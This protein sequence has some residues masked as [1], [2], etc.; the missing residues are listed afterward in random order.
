[1]RKRRRALNAIIMSI[2]MTVGLF[3][4]M[5]DAL[6]V[7]AEAITVTNDMTIN[8]ETEDDYHLSDDSRLNVGSQGKVKGNIYCSGGVVVNEGY[9]RAVE[10]S[11][12]DFYN[13]SG[14]TVDSIHAGYGKV[15]NKGDITNLGLA[16]NSSTYASVLEMNGGKVGT[17]SSDGSMGLPQIKLSSGTIQ[18]LNVSCDLQALGTANVDNLGGS[19]TLSGSG[20]VH[21]GGT[22]NLS[23]DY[24]GTSA[25]LSVDKNTQITIAAG[26]R[27]K[28]YYN[29]HAYVLGT[30]GTGTLAELAGRTV[31][32]AAELEDTIDW[33]SS[34]SFPTGKFL[35]GDEVTATFTA[36]DGY[37]FPTG[38]AASTSGN[39]SIST[40]RN[41]TTKITVTYI[42]AEEM[43]DTVTVTLPPA[44]EKTQP[45]TETGTGSVTVA[46]LYYGTQP[47]P[48]AESSTN[49]TEGVIYEY[50]IRGAA[51]ST[52]ST[53]VPEQV[54]AYTLRATFPR[55][56]HYT[57][58]T[59]V[60]DFSIYYLPVPENPCTISG[61]IG[62]NNF[63]ISRLEV[64]PPEGYKI[65]DT[66]GGEYKDSILVGDEKA[67]AAI[68]LMRQKD[69][70]KTAAI[71]FGTY[72]IDITPPRIEA[73]NG[74]EYF[75]DY[76]EIS[77]SDLRLD[78]ISINGER[79]DFG[80]TSCTAEL[81]SNDESTEYVIRAVDEAGN[82]STVTVIIS[83]EWLKTGIVPADRVLKLN[84]QREY[85][86][87]DGS[88]KVSGDNNVYNGGQTFYVGSRGSYT[89]TVN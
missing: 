71:P 47:S 9:V 60:C 15:V 85:K 24:S 36:A 28:V 18:N 43:A 14:A 33:S 86:L 8:T 38:Y 75:A 55:K 42:F 77:I 4:G 29:N 2:V 83:A 78:G 32:V 73:E 62:K 46:D 70:A 76:K 21:V 72:K 82:E 68:Y 30:P 16:A 1:M 20:T 35:F 53:S 3:F 63:Y 41:S 50:K 10:S 81:S 27:I 39:G 11:F 23:G 44:E 64:T 31:N 37:C 7:Y 51:D 19:V 54:G 59:A 65:A 25:I 88:W 80:G 22:L 6:T 26:S 66:D 58:T 34:T 52:Y 89:F 12:A 79:V 61:K 13:E 48:R 57:E 87:G 74:K 56:G 49:G 67:P 17:V 84:P 45:E 69:G 5:E 40:K